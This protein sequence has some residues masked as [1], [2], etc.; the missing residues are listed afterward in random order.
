MR[1]LQA[2][3]VNS[4]EAADRAASER[5]ALEAR[6]REVEARCES[7][8]AELRSKRE[9]LAN[10][11]EHCRR[12]R[13]EATRATEAANAERRAGEE[14]RAATAEVETRRTQLADAL[15]VAEARVA[16]AARSAEAARQEAAQ[17]RDRHSMAMDAAR[18]D[19]EA[20]LE[21]LRASK[22]EESS[23]G[24]V[25][26]MYV[27]LPR[28]LCHYRLA[29]CHGQAERCWSVCMDGCIPES[30]GREDHVPISPRSV[31]HL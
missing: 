10:A 27:L 16:E 22:D 20:R 3:L 29:W 21:S 17:L 11:T 28:C 14:A 4:Q 24:E 19:F 7:L 18:A 1:H 26:W 31:S 13:E 5:A 6:L 15:A 9:S 30:L 2:S 25:T 12:A 23:S 8:T